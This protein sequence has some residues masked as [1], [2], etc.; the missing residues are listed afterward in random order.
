M[1]TLSMFYGIVIRMFAEGDAKHKL[2]HFHVQYGSHYAVYD[3]DGRLLSGSLPSKQN[4]LVVA[5]AALHHDELCA[6]W[7]ML[8][9]GETPYK[10]EPL[11]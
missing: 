3:L 2:P 11:R 5:W 10:I 6:N 7:D 8:L 9:C 1:P 4:K